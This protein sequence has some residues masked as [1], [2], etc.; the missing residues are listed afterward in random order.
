MSAPYTVTKGVVLRQTDTKEADK[1][2]DD[3]QKEIMEI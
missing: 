2:A 1:M 3:K